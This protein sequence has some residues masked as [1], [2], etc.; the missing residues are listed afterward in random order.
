MTRKIALGLALAVMVTSTPVEAQLR[1]LLKKKAGEVLGKK[2]EPAPPA[3]APTTTTTTPTA[4]PGA[5]APAPTPAATPAA[6][7]RGAEKRDVSPLDISQLPVSQSA[8]QVLRGNIHVRDNG[9]WEQLPSIPAAAVAAAYA[10]AEPAQAALV[11]TVGGALKA[12]V[13]SAPFMAEHDKYIQSQ[14]KAVD[15]GLKGVVT[16]E[17]AMKKN[18]FKSLEAIQARQ[19]VAMGVDRIKMMPPDML[20][21]EFT[22]MVA[23]WKENAKNTKRSDVA[24]LQK[25]I[26]RA[27]PLEALAGSDEKFQRGY[28]VLLSIEN[29]GPD[30]EEAVYAIH[31]RVTQEQEQAAYDEHNLKGQLKRQLTTF[32]AVA[33]K[34]NFNAPTVE[35]G[36]R[37]LFTNPADE[38]Q[39]ALWKACFRA[40]EA[41][42]AA[43]V[44][45][46]KA[47]LSEL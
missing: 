28:A 13:M 29:D 19:V 20:K 30:T 37:T 7:A 26:A 39:G 40:G 33:A 10:L 9:D 3:P 2:P 31:Q 46:A 6:P 1:G 18:D 16:I 45:L 11:D 17:T 14:H 24:K 22:Q 12:L 4:A 5:D 25:L 34:V 8:N 41:P 44:K 43:A 47:W 27:Q 23:Q 32:I 36:G 35:K 15:H 38:R 21:R 42:T